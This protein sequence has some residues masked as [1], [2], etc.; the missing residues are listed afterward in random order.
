MSERSLSNTW[1]FSVKYITAFSHLE[2]MHNTT[3][4]HLGAILNSKITS[5]KQKNVAINILGGKKDT[6][7]SARA[8]TS[9]NITLV[10]LTWE[11]E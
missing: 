5:K 3:A 10:S 1:I 7:Y 11:L 8:E 6:F 4:L 2:I 9:Q